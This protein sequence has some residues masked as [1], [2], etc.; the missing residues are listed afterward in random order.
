MEEHQPNLSKN[1]LNLKL[2][3][4]SVILSEGELYGR[5][6]KSFLSIMEIG[7][8]LMVRCIGMKRKLN[9]D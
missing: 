4:A 7:G 5:R 8:G 6:G 2:V 3:E 9:V 1:H